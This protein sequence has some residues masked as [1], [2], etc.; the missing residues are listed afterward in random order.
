M[1][2]D[3]RGAAGVEHDDSI[4]VA[5]GGEPVGDHDR[6]A[7]GHQFLE[8]MAHGL[9]VDGV[10][11]GCRFVEDEHLGVLQERARDGD[12]LTLSAGEPYPA[13][14]DPGFQAVRKG[15]DERPSEAR[16]TASSSSAAV[17]IRFR[18]ENVG[19]QRLVEEVGVLGDQRDADRAVRRAGIR[20]DRGHR[21]G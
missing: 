9:F 3:L 8:G 16:F 2:A 4:G 18:D 21:T 20:A 5:H 15:L 6:G 19:P 10:E 1:V 14:A 17:A 12:T 11:M 13:L 7:F